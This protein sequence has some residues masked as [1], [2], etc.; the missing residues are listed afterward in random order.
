MFFLARYFTQNALAAFVAGVLFDFSAYHFNI[1]SVGQTNL[2]PIGTIPLYILFLHKSI[3]PLHPESRTVKPW[4]YP[5]LAVLVLTLAAYIDWYYPLYLLLYSGGLF[6]VTLARQPKQW[7]KLGLKFGSI[8]APWLV[9]VGPFLVLTLQA[10]NDPNMKFIPTFD[11]EVIHSAPLFSLFTPLKDTRIAPGA[12]Q[13]AFFGYTTTALAIIGLW[14]CRKQRGWWLWWLAVVIICAV[15]SLGP[16]LRLNYSDDISKTIKQGLPLPYL[17]LQNIP[18]ISLSRSPNR[19]QVM[20]EMALAILAAFGITGLSHLKFSLR[21]KQW[22]VIA[23]LLVTAVFCGEMQTLP[24]PLQQMDQPAIFKQIA[25]DPGEFA[26][27]ELPITNHGVEDAR[28]MYYQTLHHHP[29]A[30][31]YVARQLIDFYRTNDSPFGNYFDR[32]SHDSSPIIDS[33]NSNEAA[34]RLLNL[35]NFRYLVLYKDEFVSDTDEILPDGSDPQSVALWQQNYSYVQHLLGEKAQI[36]QDSN[37]TVFRVPA[38][39]PTQEPVIYGLLNW[40]DL[41]TPKASPSYRW[42]KNDPSLLIINPQAQKV[43]LSLTAF[44]LQPSSKFS[45]QLND[46]EVAQITLNGP[47]S[48]YTTPVFDLPAG[49]DKIVL[50]NLAPAISPQVLDPNSKDIRELTLGASH[51]QLKLAN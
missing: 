39:S 44:A 2:M 47:A 37:I 48:E 49:S 12:W 3:A 16:Y 31:G 45:V 7:L 1:L 34:L 21:F 13:Q 20:V 28:R 29:I 32:F 33:S 27:M 30:G 46:Q 18:P 10:T 41:E 5:V 17:W 23:P 24:W 38:A 36:Y 26:I 42:A 43:Q 11:F 9:L 51:I 25:A 22:Q 40:Y 4:L 19:F 6:V 15:L 14:F 35:Y 8:L 50:H